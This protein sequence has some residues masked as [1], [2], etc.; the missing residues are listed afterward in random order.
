MADYKHVVIIGVDGAGAFF[1]DTE[2]PN[3][4]RIFNSGAKTYRMRTTTP[5]SS[6]P[7]WMSFLHGVNPEHHG[8]I[9][10]YYVEKFPFPE[11]AKRYP[12]FLKLAKEAFPDMDSA[13][14]YNW[15]GIN[16][17]IED[18]AGI[19]K[20]RFDDAALADYAAGEYLDNNTPSVLFIHLGGADSMGHGYGY[21]SPEHL[22]YITVTDGYIGR[23]FDKLEERGMTDDTLFI[24]TSDHGGTTRKSHGGL[25]DE[26]K[27]V[28][29]AA[30]GRTVE[31]GGEPSDMEFRD[32]AAVVLYALGIEI[33]EVYTAR[34]PSGLFLGVSAKDRPSY[35]DERNVRGRPARRTKDTGELKKN[36]EMPKLISY[37]SFDNGT[38]PYEA[39]GEVRPTEGYFGEAVNLDDGYLRLE[40]FNPESR[41]FSISAWIKTPFCFLDAPL[42]ANKPSEDFTEVPAK[43]QTPGFLL[44]SVRNTYVVPPVHSMRLDLS[45]GGETIALEAPLPDDFQYGWVHVTLVVDRA[46]GMVSLYYDFDCVAKAF[47]WPLKKDYSIGLPCLTVGQ[48]GTGEYRFKFGVSVDE[49]M[50]WDGALTEEN[51]KALRHYYL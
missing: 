50:I 9:E 24:V 20:Q 48:D 25:S 33:P 12:S 32:V 44:C 7:C 14:F 45:L 41:S 17:V 47:F 51:I 30:R 4:D 22:D 36:A 11:S 6:C 40:D 49:L 46:S 1:K 3:I 39:H 13:A 28:M 34:V 18:D 31:C 37:A 8:T 19:T 21:G 23:I 15:I 10:N 42:F 35:Y 2:T 26:E 38:E 27:Y 43:E 5:T 29:F 16:G